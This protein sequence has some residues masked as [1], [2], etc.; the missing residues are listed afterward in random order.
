MKRLLVLSLFALLTVPMS[1][2][3]TQ[4]SAVF[5]A[6]MS[7]DNEVPPVSAPG[8]SGVATITVRVTRGL[9]GNINA[10]T[11]I[12]DIDYT[13]PGPVT[14]TGLHIHNGV[15][16]QNGSVVINTGLSGANTL[17]ASG[18][19]HITKVV[20]YASTDADGLKW[21]T[22]LLD[23]PENYYVNIHTT[24]NA[25]GLMRAPLLRTSL[26]FRP[27]M[28]TSQE[29]PPTS[30]VDAE[31]AALIQVLVNRNSAGAITSGT[32]TFDVDYRI[33]A[34][35]TITGLHIHNA[36]EGVNGS[37]VIDSG[38]NGST[39]SVT[40]TTGRGN[41][42]RITDIDSTN[43]AGLATL[44][45]LMSD[46]TRFYV[47]LHTSTSAAGLIRGQLSTDTYAF[48][49]LMTQA[50]EVPN[51]NST[52]VANTMTIVKVVRDSTGNIA[53]GA[54]SFNVAY[55]G[56]GGAQTFTGLHIHNQVFG[57]NGGVVINTGLS[58]TNN[59]VSPDGN[60]SVNRDVVIDGT[61][62]TTL[63]ALKGVL[64]NP[65][66]YY[67][68]IHTTVFAGGI[69]RAQLAREAYHY[70]T[71]MSP[72]NE[73]PAVNSSASA[74]GWVTVTV[75]RAPATG[76]VNGATVT[77]DV[78]AAGPD[79]QTTYTGLHI[80]NGSASVN[81]GVVI[82]T[83]LSGTNPVDSTTGTLNITRVVNIDPSNAA[84]ISM[85][86]TLISTPDQAYINLHTTTNSGGLER[87]QILPVVSYVPQVAGGGEWISSIAITNPS[88]SS[89]VQG[90]VDTFQ[91]SGSAMGAAYIDP[92][93]SFLIPPGGSTTVNLHNKGNLV[94]GFIR[95]YS[96]ANVSLA[97]AYNFPAFSTTATLTPVTSRMI[98]IPVA[99]TSSGTANTGIAVLNLT[100]GQL[101]LTL[102]NSI[103]L[104][105]PGG[106]RL[107]DVAAGQHIVGFVRDLFPDS[108]QGQSYV[109]TVTVESR[110]STGTGQLS[111]IALQFDSTT[112]LLTPVVV[113]PIP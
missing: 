67:V 102:R 87:S 30:S 92:N 17:A 45:A 95:V 100:A 1:W 76:A 19:G 74:T 94:T 2:A 109:A 75:S 48:F 26:T 57:V 72:A 62:A 32:V 58:G 80:H 106:S 59:V 25:G 3:D 40:T 39:R 36:A 103:G 13:L 66:N 104:P 41:L 16:G 7:T 108:P 49:G 37:V 105:V 20:N 86:N 98:S 83:G 15:A 110:A 10:A 53:S 54:V 18:A 9:D 4:D 99:V 88:A 6:A 79:S 101:L 38:L 84:Q 82:N 97:A 8:T 89:S 70:R 22:G 46:P 64:A 42:F 78:N 11:V 34:G 71:S 81:G 68:N 28:Q 90:I 24:T 44:T 69:I 93:I 33:P 65:E 77:F 47:N 112:A 60:G 29:V 43:T 52:G 107:I 73:I 14:F 27:P 23:S 35:S 63:N 31:G 50:E 61:N 56:F 96:N 85:L 111:A 51:S 91:S 5:K 55:S 21:V 12:F 113:T